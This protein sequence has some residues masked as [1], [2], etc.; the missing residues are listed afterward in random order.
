[1]DFWYKISK[2]I[3]KIYLAICIRKIHVI[4]EE[5]LKPG[6][7]IIVANHPNLSD[8]F[9]LPFVIQEK[10]HFL[11]Q[12][13][14]YNL[15]ILR[16]LL[17]KADQIPV[18]R[19]CGQEALNTALDK[20]SA[21]KVIVLFPEGKLNHGKGLHRGRPGAAVLA[22][23]SGAPIVPVGFYV[24]PENTRTFSRRVHN[25]ETRGV[26]Q[27]RGECYVNIGK[28]WRVPPSNNPE[29]NPKELR[30]LTSKIMS[31]I[32]CLIRQAREEAKRPIDQK[33]I[34]SI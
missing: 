6:P 27:V 7:K 9:V 10:L 23:K 15:P 13:E 20:L 8:G 29:I 21:G 4:G 33:K 19:G 34:I 11:I 14:T 28:P 18:V 3:I 2:Q 12:A 22:V 30:S 1:M 25:R 24:P 17:S 31:Q 16:H 32:E 5:R 26:W